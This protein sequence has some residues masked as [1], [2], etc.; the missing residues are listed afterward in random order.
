MRRLTLFMGHCTP[1][2]TILH[3]FCCRLAENR[4][5]NLSLPVFSTDLNQDEDD[6]D[7]S[8]TD[9]MNGDKCYE[10]FSRQRSMEDLL[11]I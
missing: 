5:R 10:A 1:T 3:N 7:D 2:I 11:N 8:I 6:L 9:Y 4:S